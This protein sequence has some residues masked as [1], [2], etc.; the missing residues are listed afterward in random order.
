MRL[1]AVG[2]TGLRHM[3]TPSS[4]HD[5]FDPWDLRLLCAPVVAVTV[6]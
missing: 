2:Y 1:T 6:G 5:Y 4:G 3:T